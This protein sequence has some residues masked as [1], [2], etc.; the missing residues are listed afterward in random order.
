[1]NKKSFKFNLFSN[2]TFV[3]LKGLVC[4]TS[5]ILIKIYY[6]CAQQ[7]SVHYKYLSKNKTNIFVW[8][9]SSGDR[10]LKF[11]IDRKESKLLQSENNRLRIS[12]LF[13]YHLAPSLQLFQLRCMLEENFLLYDSSQLNQQLCQLIV[14]VYP[15]WFTLYQFCSQN[16]W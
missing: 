3:Y 1:M 5:I 16:P 13:C 2:K 15:R 4:Q 12:T 10:N 6:N 9:W 8:E 14:V 7:K 11:E